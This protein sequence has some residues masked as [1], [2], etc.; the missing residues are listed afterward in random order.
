MLE[1]RR[2]ET[3]VRSGEGWEDLVS[4]ERGGGG[5]GGE[6]REEDL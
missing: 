2:S 5:M 6:E 4:K 1:G 3:L